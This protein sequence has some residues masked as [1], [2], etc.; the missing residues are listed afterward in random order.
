[1]LDGDSAAI[2]RQMTLATIQRKLERLDTEELLWVL[3]TLILRERERAADIST[4]ESAL[5]K[6]TTDGR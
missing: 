1:M 4:R 3:G 2:F 6:R 5:G